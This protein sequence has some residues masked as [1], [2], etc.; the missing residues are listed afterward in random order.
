MCDGLKEDIE[1]LCQLNPN[2]VPKYWGPSFWNTVTQDKRT[3]C[4]RRYDQMVVHAEDFIDDKDDPTGGAV[5][6]YAGAKPYWA[7]PDMIPESIKKIGS[8]TFGQSRWLGK[9]LR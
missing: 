8:H 4:Q 1:V 3:P 9:D 7:D 2:D 6:Y 5:L